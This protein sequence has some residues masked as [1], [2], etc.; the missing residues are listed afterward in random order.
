MHSPSPGNAEVMPFCLT[1]MK[2][3]ARMKALCL[4]VAKKKKKERFK[5]LFLYNNWVELCC[6]T[7]L[8]YAVKQYLKKK[9]QNEANESMIYIYTYF[10]LLV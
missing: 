1:A 9:R 5:P 2:G 8:H 6:K 4:L 7:F 3:H 10:K